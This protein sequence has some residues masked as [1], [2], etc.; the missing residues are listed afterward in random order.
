MEP[1]ATIPPGSLVLVDV[2]TV[3]T[4]IISSLSPECVAFALTGKK[5]PGFSM[6]LFSLGFQDILYKPLSQEKLNEVYRRREENEG[7]II[8]LKKLD[9]FKGELYEELCAILGDAEDSK[10]ILKKAAIASKLDIPVLITGE[11]GVGKEL[12]ARAIWRLSTRWD[13]P[14]VPINCSAIPESLFEAE[15]FGFEKGAFTGATLSKK[16]LL[17]VADGGVIFLDEIGELSL[18]LQAKLLRVLQDLMIRRLGAEKDIKIDVKIISATNRDLEK[19][20][21][22]GS[23]REDLY[24][25]ITG[26]HIHIPPLRERKKDVPI[27]LDCFIRRFAKEFGKTIFGYSERFFERIMAHPFYGNVREMENLVRKIV[28]LSSGP[29]L[30]SKDLDDTMALRFQKDKKW[31]DHLKDYVRALLVSGER[32]FFHRLIRDVEQHV[33]QEAL[34]YAGGNKVKA[35]EI[36]GINRITLARKA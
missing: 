33:V 9:I 36:L 5:H 17:E 34:S 6:F 29:F 27:L 11:S 7:K 31:E 14:F 18:N 32:K 3:G 22:S 19:M 23:F 13:K 16:G 2:D 26:F 15:L 24:H 8:P 35:S 1:G 21:E 12:L 25:R 10:G 4:G 30:T 28:A 20:V